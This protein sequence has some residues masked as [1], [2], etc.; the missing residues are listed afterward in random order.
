[1]GAFSVSSNDPVEVLFGDLLKPPLWSEFWQV[2]ENY[3]T[4][5]GGCH[6]KQLVRDI[7]LKMYTQG[8]I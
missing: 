1:V 2:K 8:G 7:Q 6:F 4:G 5:E 3:R